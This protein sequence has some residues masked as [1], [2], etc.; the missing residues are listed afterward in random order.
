MALP[1]CRAVRPGLAT[2]KLQPC[3]LYQ[4]SRRSSFIGWR[5]FK[6]L[7]QPQAPWAWWCCWMSTGQVGVDIFERAT[8]TTPSTGAGRPAVDPCEPAAVAGAVLNP[9]V[10]DQ[11]F[12][13]RFE[14]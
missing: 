6:T 1:P 10:K 7:K 14:D 11:R 2:G 9:E 8:A 12:V 5:T 3:Q 13:D 4:R